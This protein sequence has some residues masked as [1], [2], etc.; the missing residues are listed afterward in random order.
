MSKL[1]PNGG[2]D[3]NFSIN[4]ED[5]ELTSSWGHGICSKQKNTK[6][7]YLTVLEA[8]M[9]L[10]ECPLGYLLM[11]LAHILSDLLTPQPMLILLC[12]I[13]KLYS[14]SPA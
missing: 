1:P 6:R 5:P 10:S 9:S 2:C 7:K 3:L 4:R 12:H 8:H 14:V 11:G 13:I